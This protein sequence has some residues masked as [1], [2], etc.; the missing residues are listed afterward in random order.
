M[1]SLLIDEV[2]LKGGSNEGIIEQLSGEYGFDFGRALEEEE[3]PEE[4]GLRE[5][6]GGEVG[7]KALG[8]LFFFLG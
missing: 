2:E 6:L 5:A 8:E 7:S 4:E 1:Y 3:E